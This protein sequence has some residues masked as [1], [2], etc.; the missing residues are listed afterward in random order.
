MKYKKSESIK[1]H[2]V[3]LFNQFRELNFPIGDYV[4]VSGGPLAIRG[5]KKTEDV[6]LLVTDEVW[7]DLVANYQPKKDPISGAEVLKIAEDVEVISFRGAEP[8]PKAP[9]NQQQIDSA[10]IIDGLAF[11]SLDH[12]LWFK[13]HSARPKDLK[14]IELVEKWQS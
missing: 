1:E 14:D 2:N 3:R 13:K 9:T 12:C 8:E 4:I 7:E 5:I 6:D 11:Q 10:E